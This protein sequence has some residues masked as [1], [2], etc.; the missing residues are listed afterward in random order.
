MSLHFMNMFFYF[1]LFLF[2]EDYPSDQEYS[3]EGHICT[4]C[5]AQFDEESALSEHQEHC[6]KP[7]MLLFK[8]GSEKSENQAD[9]SHINGFSALNQAPNNLDD[10]NQSIKGEDNEQALNQ[11]KNKNFECYSGKEEKDEE[12]EDE[13]DQSN[14]D[15]GDSDFN[16]SVDDVD[17]DEDFSRMK[18]PSDLSEKIKS[19]PTAAD[20][21]A[22]MNQLSTM[23]PAM[24]MHSGSNV[25]LEPL[26]ATKAAVAQFAENNPEREQDVGK[27]Q[28]A[29]FNLQQQQLVQL[30]LIH[31]LQQQLVSGGQQNGQLFPG[32]PASAFPGKN[33]LSSKSPSS[34]HESPS[35]KSESPSPSEKEPQYESRSSSPERTESRSS[36]GDRRGPDMSEIGESP[37]SLLMTAASKAG[38]PSPTSTAGLLDFSRSSGKGW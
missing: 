2:S 12:D 16:K 1:S 15:N 19:N 5:Q 4:K 21:A 8:E 32:F 6:L 36:M 14:Y 23:L 22:Y 20:I 35:P 31:Q 33:L 27:L 18:D 34:Q 38:G 17:D 9:H 13:G 28:S 11:S 24:A 10:E 30:Q 26:E 37:V 7:V 25:L 29:L 3:R